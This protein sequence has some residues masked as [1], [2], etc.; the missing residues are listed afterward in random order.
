MNNVKVS[1]CMD[2]GCSK[3]RKIKKV[4]AELEKMFENVQKKE[5]V[6]LL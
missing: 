5:N 3:I 1:I 4:I 2:I 6:S